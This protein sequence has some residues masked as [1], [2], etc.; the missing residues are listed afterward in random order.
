MIENLY[1]SIPKWKKVIFVIALFLFLFLFC[2]TNVKSGFFVDWIMGTNPDNITNEIFDGLTESGTDTA[3]RVSQAADSLIH[4]PWGPTLDT[5]IYYTEASQGS[6]LNG[7]NIISEFGIWI[8]VFISTI[9]FFFSLYVYV[10]TGKITD[11]KDTPISLLAKY[12]IALAICYKLPSIMTTFLDIIDSLYQGFVLTTYGN[13]ASGQG[14]SLFTGL[15]NII[16]TF[17]AGLLG[18]AVFSALIPGAGFIVFAIVIAIF[19]PLLKG[20]FKLYMESISRYIVSVFLLLLMAAFGGTI[21]SNNTSQIFKSYLRTLISSFSVLLFNLLW[22]KICVICLCGLGNNPSIVSYIFTLEVMAFGLKI[23]GIL[24]AM[25]LGVASGASRIGSACGG[26]G[27]NLAN[28]LRAG[29]DLRQ[30]TGNLLKE[31]GAGMLAK[32]N[33]MGLGMFNAGS[34]L[35]ATASDISQGKAD[36][37]N[38]IFNAAAKLGADGR[39]ISDDVLSGKQAAGIMSKA[40]ANPNDKDAQNA[41]K[42]LSNNKLAEGAQ[43][44]VG[45]KYKVNGASFTEKFGA[46]GQKHSGVR[47]NATPSSGESMANAEASSHEKSVS[48]IISGSGMFAEGTGETFTA[49]DNAF[50]MKA[51][52]FKNSMHKGD[53]AQVGDNID[54]IAGTP[55]SDAIKSVKGYDIDGVS[56]EGGDSFIGYDG[57]TMCGVI[58]DDEFIASSL[59]D[60]NSQNALLSNAKKKLEDEGYDVSDWESDEEGKWHAIGTSSDGTTKNIDVIDR[61]TY[62]DASKNHD[63]D[64][65]VVNSQDEIGNRTSV[66]VNVSKRTSDKSGN[67]VEKVEFTNKKKGHSHK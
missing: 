38:G 24:R 31:A 45:D 17:V 33:Q 22:T 30:G 67:D 58:Q 47:V 44:I 32:G 46:D 51:D 6:S 19:W 59:N 11:C 62:T 2:V 60:P 54:E 42:A 3:D 57:D 43:E 26:A 49:N 15:T 18:G 52:E 41:M 14:T 61:G 1:Y 40:M 53:Y 25:G 63:I 7:V 64:S 37:Q 20:F 9:I 21:V 5:F 34:R 55:V 10:F 39:K 27:R 48:G 8:G 13:L 23:D 28:A 4:S 56:Y 36:P 66:F 29:K 12:I 65:F 35:G 16:L 50:T